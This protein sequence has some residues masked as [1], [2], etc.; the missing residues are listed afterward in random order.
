[1]ETVRWIHSF[2]I[3]VNFQIAIPPFAFEYEE[4]GIP[5]DGEYTMEFKYLEGEDPEL[6]D[7]MPGN[8]LSRDTNGDVYDLQSAGMVRLEIYIR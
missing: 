5:Y 1:M 8:L 6:L 2:S 4:N 7:K 3:Q